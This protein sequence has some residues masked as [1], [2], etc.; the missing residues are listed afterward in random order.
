MATKSTEN[1]ASQQSFD[2]FIRN[3]SL[4]VLVDFWADWCGPCHAQEPIIKEVAKKLSGRLKVIK[5]NVDKKPHIA[6]KYGIKGIP[7]LMLFKNGENVWQTSGV[8]QANQL[9]QQLNP[10]LD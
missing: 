8:Q 10:Y 4:P 3:S 9:I 7:T 6:G 2:E 5:V 1:G